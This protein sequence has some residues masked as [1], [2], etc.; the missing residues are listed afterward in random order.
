MMHAIHHP[1]PS[2]HPLAQL[3]CGQ[4]CRNEHTTMKEVLHGCGALAFNHNGAVSIPNE[5]RFSDHLFYSLLLYHTDNRALTEEESRCAQSMIETILDQH[6]VIHSIA[7]MDSHYDTLVQR[8]QRISD[9]E[10]YHPDT[11]SEHLDRLAHK[12]AAQR[13]TG[14]SQMSFRIPNTEINALRLTQ[15]MSEISEIAPNRS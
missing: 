9:G 13:D 6:S 15:A 3:V 11:D 1:R 7:C 8:H 10:R 2:A 5:G 12:Y 14:L 4:L